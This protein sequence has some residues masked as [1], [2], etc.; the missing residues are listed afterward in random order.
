MFTRFVYRM[1]L[2]RIVPFVPHLQAWRGVPLVPVFLLAVAVLTACGG[3]DAASGG[4][5][6]AGTQAP[7]AVERETDGG[8]AAK[9][10]ADSMLAMGD[11]GLLEAAWPAALAGMQQGATAWQPDAR[12]VQ[13]SVGC[14]W[15]VSDD[16]VDVADDGSTYILMT[17]TPLDPAAISFAELGDALAAAGYDDA[18]AVPGDVTV[19]SDADFDGEPEPHFSYVLDLEPTADGELVRLVVDGVDGTVAK[20]TS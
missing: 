19:T 18:T 12:L 4:K 14:D 5:D 7:T 17:D 9:A 10:C 11:L 1:A 13:L 16:C 6:A 8:D 15:G 20:Q 3:A 2:T